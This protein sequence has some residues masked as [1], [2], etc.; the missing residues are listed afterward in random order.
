MQSSN[1]ASAGLNSCRIS[2]LNEPRFKAGRPEMSTS[3]CET[4]FGPNGASNRVLADN[5]PHGQSTTAASDSDGT[6]CSGRPRR[7]ACGK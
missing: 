1:G 4:F 6:V 7:L 2:Q 3:I 5:R